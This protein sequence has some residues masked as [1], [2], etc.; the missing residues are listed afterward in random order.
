MSDDDSSL[1]YGLEYQTRALCAQATI[2][3]AK[4]FLIGTQSLKHTNQIHLIEYDDETNFLT[5]CIY[6]HEPG[7]IWNI[8][9][10]YE[11]NLFLTCYSS[12]GKLFT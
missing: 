12:F 6:K 5:K 11:R 4:R 10:A 1:I 8:S 2:D 9:A 7:E 3:E